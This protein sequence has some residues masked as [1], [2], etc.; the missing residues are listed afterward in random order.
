MNEAAVNEGLDSSKLKALLIISSGCTF[1]GVMWGLIYAFLGLFIP[2][3]PPFLFSFFV[4]A[5]LILYR[6]YKFE[7][8]LLNTQLTMILV[9]PVVLQWSLGGFHMSGV[10]ILWSVVGPFGAIIF[11]SNK[12]AL[13]WVSLYLFLL[14]VSLYFD[15]EF[16][17]WQPIPVSAGANSFFYGMNIIGT[18]M[19]TFLA[20]YY[21]NE[22]LAK[23]KEIQKKYTDDLNSN[24]D[25]I[26]H[27][28]E[29]LAKGDLTENIQEKSENE[30][31]NRLIGGYNR[32]LELMRSI[33]KQ[34]ENSSS[35]V[36]EFIDKITK[37]LQ[38]LEKN[39]NNHSSRINE[40][41]TYLGSLKKV[42]EDI[43]SSI[44]I[45]VAQS[46]KNLDFAKEGGKNIQVSVDKLNEV[47]VSFHETGEM[48]KQLEK[49]SIDIGE[50][51]TTIN[52]V[53]DSTNLLALNASIEAARAG[54]HGKGFAVVAT[55]IGKLTNST[56]EATSKIS[57]NIRE[58]QN[59]TKEATS[60]FAVSSKF[61]EEGKSSISNLELSIKN[62]IQTTQDS[63]KIIVNVAQNSAKESK[64]IQDIS[65]I[66]L[67]LVDDFKDILADIQTI[68][69]DSRK[70]DETA[71]EM[72]KKVHLFKT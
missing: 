23:E 59:R 43:S 49:I 57:K 26:L 24:V 34:L 41:E 14:I 60:R 25:V 66:I 32:S 65:T 61:M 8:L 28:I 70:L 52:G 21:Y 72:I 16:K 17:T 40:I 46:V 22:T 48:I 39:I 33:L 71:E 12:K 63:N 37:A 64:Q 44:Q 50:I 15:S 10:V 3:I 36:S 62:I 29:Q 68:Y 51:T 7:N 31:M 11:Q 1:A 35:Q 42:M 45:S 47:G 6:L 27:S 56:S 9:I 30:V 69:V 4:G 2:M 55:E 54:V 18:S 13:F 53:S 19:V 38:H 20:I 67:E 5:A 58:I